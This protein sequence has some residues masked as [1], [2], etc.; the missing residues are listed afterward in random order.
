MFLKH[1]SHCLNSWIISEL[2]ASEN[3]TYTFTGLNKYEADGSEIKYEVVEKN[4]P[5]GY[6][7]LVL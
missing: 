7:Y 6:T 3:W 1:I 4:V 5:E 2:K